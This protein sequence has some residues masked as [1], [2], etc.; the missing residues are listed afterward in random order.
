MGNPKYALGGEL[1]SELYL[2]YFF[3]RQSAGDQGRD[4][5]LDKDHFQLPGN[6]YCL[7]E[8]D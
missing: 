5:A 3:S 6:P 8:Q 7:T 1:F 2:D 4:T